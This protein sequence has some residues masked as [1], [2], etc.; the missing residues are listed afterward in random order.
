[1]SKN[2]QDVLGI[3]MEK[4]RNMVS[5]DTV[6]GT[7]LV[8]DGVTVVPVSRI[9]CGFVGGGADLPTKTAGEPFGGGSGAGV[10]VVP[11]AF[12]VVKD[13][14]VKVMPVQDRPNSLDVALSMIPGAVDKIA[15]TVS[16]IVSDVTA[17]RD[18]YYAEEE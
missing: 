18:A 14:D 1:M 15:D 5:A 2:V 17:R 6:I 7:P 16:G 13:G 3:S 8:L 4:V 10:N 9:S 11:G 12:L